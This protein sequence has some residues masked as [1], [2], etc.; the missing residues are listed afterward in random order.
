VKPLKFYTDDLR[1]EIL[2]W[3]T[4]NQKDIGHLMRDVQNGEFPAGA[5]WF[6]GVGPG[7]I[8]L[9]SGAYRTIV[10]I[11]FDD[12]VWVIHAFTKDAAKGRQT[13]KQH[14]DLVKQRVRELVS[15]Y[16]R[17]N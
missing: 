6:H 3:P 13:R 7:V 9:K 12:I 5:K 1:D 16:G 14:T 17:P 4:T 11:E 15:R 8:Q 2:G 10:T